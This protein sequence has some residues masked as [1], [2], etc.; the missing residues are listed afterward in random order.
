MKLYTTDLWDIAP[1]H[2]C[3]DGRCLAVIVDTPGIE[4]ILL[5]EILALT[6]HKITAAGDYCWDNDL[7][8]IDWV[9]QTDF[10]WDDFKELANPNGDYA[11]ASTMEIYADKGESA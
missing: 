3:G 6:G 1:V 11:N 9:W 10:P 2:F 7:D 5:R 4:H 8:K